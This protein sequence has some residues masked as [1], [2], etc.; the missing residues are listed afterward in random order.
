MPSF[1]LEI[2]VLK[3]GLNFIKNKFTKDG[4]LWGG[5]G[6]RSLNDDMVR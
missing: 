3:V 2:S 6:R 5:G 1:F 4:Y